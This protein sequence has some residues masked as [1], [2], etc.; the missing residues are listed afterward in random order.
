MAVDGAQ[1]SRNGWTSKVY[2][3]LVHPTRRRRLQLQPW[4]CGFFVISRGKLQHFGAPRGTDRRHLQRD[5][6]RQENWRCIA[7]GC[8]SDMTDVVGSKL[9][10]RQLIGHRVCRVAIDLNNVLLT[11]FRFQFASREQTTSDFELQSFQR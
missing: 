2:G 9:M 6:R 4:Q 7:D 8:N 5:N 11:Q 3:C 10:T 1:R